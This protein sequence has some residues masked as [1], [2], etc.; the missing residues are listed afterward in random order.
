MILTFLSFQTGKGQTLFGIENYT[1]D[2]GLPSSCIVSIYQNKDGFIGVETTKGTVQFDGYEF[3]SLEKNKS[4]ENKKT[5]LPHIIKESFLNKT[6]T[7]V[8]QDKQGSYWVGTKFN[9]VYYVPSYIGITQLEIEKPVY[10]FETKGDSI[11]F[12]YK[13]NEGIQY[14]VVPHGIKTILGNTVINSVKKN[15]AY[16]FVATSK[17]LYQFTNTNYSDYKIITTYSGLSSNEVY[18]IEFIDSQLYV[19][20]RNGVSKI[21]I[22]KFNKQK[23]KATVLFPYV[24]LNNEKHLFPK[25]KIVVQPEYNFLTLRYLALDYKAK[26]NQLYR[27]KID[28]IHKDWVVTK[29]TKIQFTSLPPKGEYVFEVQVQEAGGNWS[30]SS[31]IGLNFLQVFYKSWWFIS[32]C[33]LIGIGIIS[34]LIRWFYQR[35]IKQEQLQSS[36]LQLENKALQSQM[37]PHFVFNALNSIQSFITRGDTLNS[38]V[39]LAKFSNLLRKTLNHSRENSI[40]LSKELEGLEMYLELEKMRFG[41]KLTYEISLDESVEEDFIKVPPMLLQPFVE[42]AIVHG[43]APKVNGGKIDIVLKMISDNELYC[44]VIDNGVGR[45]EKSITL[46]KSLGT[47]IVNKRLRIINNINQNP[48]T[49]TD[50][51]DKNNFPVGTKVEFIIP[52]NA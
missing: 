8:L 34:V 44:V 11:S 26:G 16:T 14:I 52:I 24:R 17:G 23:E 15:E 50:L 42:N 22:Q 2:N 21:D 1:I 4:Q 31:K 9:G 10:R 36:L 30:E 13:R 46:H 18:D 19:A 28:G 5:A 6:V 47:D 33:L 7:S 38:E 51:K 27:Y 45:K 20:V 43:I 3:V 40:E 37:N 25:G 49:Y 32:L 48:I 39:Y 12:V 29:D 41:E 35:K